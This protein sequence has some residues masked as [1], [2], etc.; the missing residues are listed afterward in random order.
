MAS[1]LSVPWCPAAWRPRRRWRPRSW[2]SAWRWGR[3]W[4]AS[5]PSRSRRRR[6]TPGTA[7]GPPS[8][9]WWWE[10]VC[11]RFECVQLPQLTTARR[12][13]SNLFQSFNVRPSVPWPRW[14]LS[15]EGREY[16]FCGGLLSTG[17]TLIT[18]GHLPSSC[19]VN[20]QNKWA[21]ANLSLVT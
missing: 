4:P 12:Y 5:W 13:N 15:L 6:R 7:P 18:L 17:T 14:A 20:T 3:T 11:S 8:C 19:N 16:G 1:L 2:T 10:V 9:S 21:F